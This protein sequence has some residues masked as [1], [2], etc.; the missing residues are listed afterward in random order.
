MLA[1]VSFN[2]H[3]AVPQEERRMEKATARVGTPP[4]P[5]ASQIFGK[6]ELA[7]PVAEQLINFK[8]VQMN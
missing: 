1:S 8:T 7:Q 4:D 5:P 3:N 6:S 2:L